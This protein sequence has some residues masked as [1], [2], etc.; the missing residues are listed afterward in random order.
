LAILGQVYPRPE[1]RR[2]HYEENLVYQVTKIAA[3]AGYLPMLYTDADY[4]ASNACYVKIGYI[5]RGK[6]CTIG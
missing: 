6:L 3:Q 2:K 4:A 1:F 5:L